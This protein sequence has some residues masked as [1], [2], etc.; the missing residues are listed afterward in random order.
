MHALS[1]YFISDAY[2]SAFIA[3]PTNTEI[4]NMLF[5]LH[6]QDNSMAMIWSRV[7]ELLIWWLDYI[8]CNLLFFVF[9]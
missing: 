8:K 3:V 2:F 4:E 6:R 9:H 1:S 7:H 5:Y